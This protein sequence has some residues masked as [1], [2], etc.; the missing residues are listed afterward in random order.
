MKVGEDVR[1][2]GLKVTPII[3]D[4][5]FLVGQR[6][7]E[8]R[9]SAF[10]LKWRLTDILPGN[11]TKTLFCPCGVIMHVTLT[12]IQNGEPVYLT[13]VPTGGSDVALYELTYTIFGTIS[14]ASGGSQMNTPPCWYQMGITRLANWTKRS[15][16]P[17]VP[18]YTLI[19]MPDSYN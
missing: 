19:R 13:N 6:E 15:S 11:Q 4:H 10:S 5:Y 17:W 3:V 9:M 14:E 8:T 7:R 16:S 18:N 2:H 1:E 12:D